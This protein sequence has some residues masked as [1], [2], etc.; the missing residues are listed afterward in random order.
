VAVIVDELVHAS[1]TKGGA[2]D[3]SD[4]TTG[5]DVADELG[6]SLAG[7]R[8]FFEKDDLGLLRF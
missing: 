2:D 3:I 1:W 6:L 5:V 7:I 4:G 8:A